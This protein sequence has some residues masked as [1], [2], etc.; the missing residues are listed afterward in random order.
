M[1]NN[2]LKKRTFLC[3]ILSLHHSIGRLPVNA[4]GDRSAVHI[5]MH[6]VIKLCSNIIYLIAIYIS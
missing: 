2:D 4:L 3:F 5:F 6:E 1:I